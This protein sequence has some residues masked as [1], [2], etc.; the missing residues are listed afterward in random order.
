MYAKTGISFQN[1]MTINCRTEFKRQ[2]LG[3]T[4]IELLVVIAIIA[5]LAGMLLPALSKAKERAY[6]VKCISNSKQMALAWTLYSGDNNDRLSGNIDGL[7]AQN[8]ANSNATWCVGWLDNAAFR[9]DNTNISLLMHSQL[10]RYSSSPGIYVCPADRSKSRGSG[11]PP[12]V[13][14]YSMNGYMGE[15]AEP[16]TPGYQQFSKQSEF[17]RLGPSEAFVFID[18]REDSINDSCFLVDMEG[19]DPRQGSSHVWMNYPGAYH[20]R[21]GVL[22]YA[23]NHVAQQR[24]RDARTVPTLIRGQNLPL[25]QGSANNADLDWIQSHTSV[26]GENPTR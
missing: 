2:S 12:R 3:F 10:G 26:R 6:T 13:R 20:S 25:A 11:G 14:S 4:L 19:Y 16:F 22:A 1:I 18:E 23:D 15:K 17:G 24:W 8:S 21:G 5:I 9:S 7:A